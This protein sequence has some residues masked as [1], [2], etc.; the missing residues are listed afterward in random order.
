[1]PFKVSPKALDLDTANL[2]DSSLFELMADHDANPSGATRA[3][4]EFY[5]RYSSYLWNC[6]LHVCRTTTEGDRLAKDIFQSSIQKIY[7]QAR[8]YDSQKAT[9]VKAWISR[10]AYHEFID[11]YN[12]YDRNFVAF[13]QHS[14]ER[15]VADDVWEEGEEETVTSIV[16]GLKLEQLKFLLSKLSPKEFKV[17]M[18]YM[19]HFQ[20][21]K[22]TSHLPDSQMRQLCAEFNV[23]SDAI[24][25]I[26]RRALDK[27]KRWT[28]EIN[29]Q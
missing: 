14:H 16:L 8:K 7:V 29:T 1:M 4:N 20:L 9:G 25:Q 5:H 17:L 23:K 10:I 3:W 2:S 21:D 22:P 27:L 12:K 11:Y 26:K 19:S 6:C 24:R 28:R 18:T 15:G 13:D